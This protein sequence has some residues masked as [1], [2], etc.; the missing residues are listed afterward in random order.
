MHTIQLLITNIIN[1]KMLQKYL[2][3]PP[4]LKNTS[5]PKEK[6]KGYPCLRIIELDTH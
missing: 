3:Q 5:S 4:R 1:K 6:Q 2:I